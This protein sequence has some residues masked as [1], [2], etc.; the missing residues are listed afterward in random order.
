[1][2]PSMARVLFGLHKDGYTERCKKNIVHQRRIG[3]YRIVETLLFSGIVTL[4]SYLYIT[5]RLKLGGSNAVAAYV[6][7]ITAVGYVVNSVNQA[8][9]L[10]SQAGKA[11]HVYEKYP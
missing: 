8:L 7:M 10:F 5:W 9:G 2:Y 6:A 4:G 11:L 3:G 1:M